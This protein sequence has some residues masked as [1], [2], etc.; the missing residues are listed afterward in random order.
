MRGHKHSDET[1][2]AVTAA[3]LAGQGVGEVATCYQIDKSLVSRWRKELVAT[4][5]QQLQ[6]KTRDELE[7]LLM[8]YVRQNLKT[9]A[10]QSEV[11]GREDYIKK[12]PASELA[13]LHGV[14]ADKTFRILSALQPEPEQEP[15]FVN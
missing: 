3:L 5:V 2:A 10:A 7:S 8:N 15:G 11:A 13:V 1:R 9:L 12:Q 4:G 6:P 14:M